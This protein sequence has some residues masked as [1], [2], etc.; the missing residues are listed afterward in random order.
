VLGQALCPRR[1]DHIAQFLD[2]LAFTEYKQRVGQSSKEAAN[3]QEQ[4][5]AALV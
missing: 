3:G 4:T 1:A 5:V 2:N